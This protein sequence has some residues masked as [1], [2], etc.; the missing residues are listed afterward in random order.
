MVRRALLL[1]LL[2]ASPLPAMADQYVVQVGDTLG[3]IAQHHHVSVSE[4]ARVNGIR[5]INLV[6]IGETLLI[7]VHQQ[8]Q[9]YRVQ[10]GDT[11]SGIAVKFGMD[12]A[13]IRS[14]NP[15]LGT[16]PLAGQLLR[17]CSPCS[18]SSGSTASSGGGYQSAAAATSGQVH[19]VRPGETLSSIAALYGESTAV[20]MSANGIQ[21]PNLIVIGQRL[22][23]PAAPAV[24]AAG[25]YDPTSARALITGYAAQYGIAP[26]LP[27]AIAWQESG[28]NQNLVSVTGAVGVMQI[29]PYTMDHINF[30]LGTHFNIYNTD[31]NIHAGVYW[32]WVLLRYYGGDERLAVAAYYEGTRNIAIHGLFRDTVQ[33][34]NDVV[35]L[36]SSFG[37]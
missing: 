2:F 29:E 4:L 1:L 20:L 31:D 17:L 22:S 10:W 27:L 11:L 24:P 35:A 13:T 15:S 12:I 6:R 33:Y 19:I 36:Q 21:N 23:V 28:F 16:F 30:L 5:D 18:S 8:N 34:V 26:S 9:W 14:M 3:S 37:G 32:L 7:P 25:I